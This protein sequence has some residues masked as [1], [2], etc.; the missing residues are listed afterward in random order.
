[1]LDTGFRGLTA[2]SFTT[3]SGQPPLVLVCL[4]RFS[5]TRTAVE[6]TGAFNISVLG[7]SQEFFAERFAGRAPA[8][9]GGWREIPHRLG[10]NGL[11]IL[12]GS[13]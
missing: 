10:A 5:A 11:P 2:S 3:V 13:I 4:D 9:D 12:D 8:V 1:R 6:Q 7:R